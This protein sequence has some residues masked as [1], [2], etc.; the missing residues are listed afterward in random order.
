MSKEDQPYA[1]GI[2]T[3]GFEWSSKTT[4]LL[5]PRHLRNGF[6]L[7]MRRPSFCGA[8]D[9]EGQLTTM[10]QSVKLT[11]LNLLSP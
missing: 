11:S 8:K 1:L 2:M 3:F 5:R 9:A 10:L 6:N 7:L 4:H